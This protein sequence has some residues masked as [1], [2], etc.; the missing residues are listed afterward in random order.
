VVVGDFNTP[1]LPIHRSS[2][3]KNQWR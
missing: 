1:L 2:R 3:Q